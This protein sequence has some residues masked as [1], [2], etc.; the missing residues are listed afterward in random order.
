MQVSSARI[1]ISPG[2]PEFDAGH[3]GRHAIHSHV[4]DDTTGVFN[5]EK[6]SQSWSNSTLVVSLEWLPCG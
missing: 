4:T 6:I 1:L 3:M 5:I 2:S